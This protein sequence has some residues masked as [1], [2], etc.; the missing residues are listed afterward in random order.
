[1]DSE[2]VQACPSLTAVRTQTPSWLQVPETQ[3]DADPHTPPVGVA[4]NPPQ[5][6]AMQNPV[7]HPIVHLN[8]ELPPST[9]QP[10]RVR[11]VLQTSQGLPGLRTPC[12]YPTPLITHPS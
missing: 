7:K 8:S 12:G 3:V 4:L 9:V 10:V 5:A 2:G 11:L 1:M 6:P